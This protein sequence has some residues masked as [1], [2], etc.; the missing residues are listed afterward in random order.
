MAEAASL[1]KFGIQL[2][3][4]TQ[5]HRVH[6]IYAPR[7]EPADDDTTGLLRR[8]VGVPKYVVLSSGTQIG[9]HGA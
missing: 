5:V 4:G 9:S 3:D 1:E 6:V 7:H 8:V 2:H